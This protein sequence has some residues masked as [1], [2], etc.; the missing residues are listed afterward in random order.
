LTS[1]LRLSRASRRNSVLE[2]GTSID[3]H[4]DGRRLDRPVCRRSP[5][6]PAGHCR[7]PDRSAFRLKGDWRRTGDLGLLETDGENLL[8]HEIEDALST[9]GDI[10]APGGLGHGS[11]VFDAPL[12]DTGCRAGAHAAGQLAGQGSRSCPRTGT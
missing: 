5:P 2:A 10:D 4:E 12:G 7:Q 6:L 1:Y 8:A 9:L 3:T 11:R